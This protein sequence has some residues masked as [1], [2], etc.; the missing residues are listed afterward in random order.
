MR[1]A[2]LKICMRLRLVSKVLLK[3]KK[4]NK[5]HFNLER[6]AIVN[7]PAVG[8]N[9]PNVDVAGGTAGG[10]LVPL[11]IWPHCCRTQIELRVRTLG[12]SGPFRQDGT[13][14]KRAARRWQLRSGDLGLLNQVR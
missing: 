1:G 4:V 12:V 2:H 14:Q 3:A 5:I 9:G 6:L 7:H 11:S 10:R 13:D 8:L